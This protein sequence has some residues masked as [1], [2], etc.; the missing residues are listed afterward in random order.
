M[1][2]RVFDDP[3][4]DVEVRLLPWELFPLELLDP[5][6][7]ARAATTKRAATEREAEPR[8]ETRPNDQP[9]KRGNAERPAY[10]AASASSSSI[11][12]S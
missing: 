11:L 6:P 12:N 7:V 4:V 2:D 9:L 8:T 5:H 3:V 10:T 1:G